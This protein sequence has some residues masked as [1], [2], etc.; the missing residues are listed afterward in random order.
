MEDCVFCKIASG[1][2]QGLRICEDDEAL[3]FMDISKIMTDIFL[4]YPRSTIDTRQ[5]VLRMWLVRFGP[6]YI[7]SLNI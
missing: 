3:A 6:W 5:I 4:L 7:R 1:E 2:I